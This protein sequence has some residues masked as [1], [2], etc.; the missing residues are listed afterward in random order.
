MKP[1]PEHG[2]QDGAGQDRQLTRME[3]KAQR[4]RESLLEKISGNAPATQG[5]RGVANIMGLSLPPS[6]AELTERADIAKVS[7]HWPGLRTI[8]IVNGKGGSGKTPTT[9]LLSAVLA[10]YGGGGVIAWDNN[11]TRGTLGWRTEQADHDRTVA[12]LI[13]AAEQFLQRDSRLADLDAYTHHQRVDRFNV[14]RSKPELLS[15]Q[16]PSDEA[17]FRAVHA[18]LARACRIIMIDTGNDESTPAWSAMIAKADALVVP[19]RTLPE[20]AESARLLL[21]E[22]ACSSDQ[23]AAH[24]AGE[25][26]IVVSQSGKAEPTPERY[27]GIFNDM[28]GAAV[29]IPYDP[30]MSG[31]PLLLDSLAPPTRRAWIR[32]AAALADAL[33]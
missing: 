22:L 4:R 27:V 6:P 2:Q 24:L 1:T 28:A 29:G 33:G 14:L 20:H 16:Q 13:P 5:L 11:S 15:T 7:Q 31:S 8:A 9:I 30:G 32:A 18:V 10:R 23:H 3:L 26:I 25:A 17:S 19:T 21:D 12:D